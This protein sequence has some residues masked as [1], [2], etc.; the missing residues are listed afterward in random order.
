MIIM[1]RIVC[2]LL[3]LVILSNVPVAFAKRAVNSKDYM[4]AG[5]FFS[6]IETGTEVTFE[7]YLF[8][9]TPYVDEDS[10]CLSFV[11]LPWKGTQYPPCCYIYAREED[12]NGIEASSLANPPKTCYVKVSGKA[13]GPAKNDCVFIYIMDGQGSMEIINPE[14]EVFYLDSITIAEIENEA[15]N[16]LDNFIVENGVVVKTDDSNTRLNHYVV[17]VKCGE[18]TVEF[19][20]MQK[21]FFIDDKVSGR[22]LFSEITDDG[23]IRMMEAEFTLIE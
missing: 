7:A 20:T 14:P 16:Y 12:F 17:W 21:E 22:G 2:V 1:K 4:S 6:D 15:V 8:S 19:Q 23:V 18:C 3:L 10:A 11:L 13:D 5:D 9:T